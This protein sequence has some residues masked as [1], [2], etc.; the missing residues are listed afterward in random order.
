MGSQTIG[1]FARQSWNEQTCEINNKQSQDAEKVFQLM[2]FHI[3]KY[4]CKGSHNTP[5]VFR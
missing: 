2:L 5:F 4:E 1:D 3:L